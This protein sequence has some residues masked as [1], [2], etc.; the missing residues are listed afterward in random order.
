METLLALFL[1]AGK[2][3]GL[4]NSEK[5]KSEWA[6]IEN[7]K[8]IEKEA[9]VKFVKEK[10]RKYMIEAMPAYLPFKERVADA[11]LSVPTKIFVEQFFKALDSYLE[12]KF[13]YSRLSVDEFISRFFYELGRKK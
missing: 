10:I 2:R 13:E 1:E 5:L 8:E 3:A 11:I 4:Y 12:E 7:N 9:A 6:K